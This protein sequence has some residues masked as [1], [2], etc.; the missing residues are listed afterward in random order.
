[1]TV[2]K[3]TFCFRPQRLIVGNSHRSVQN[4]FPTC[5]D[6]DDPHNGSYVAIKIHAH[7]KVKWKVRNPYNR[8]FAQLFI[9]ILTLLSVYC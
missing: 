1:M 9:L 4:T 2:L 6:R 8:H 7:K 5:S 3:H